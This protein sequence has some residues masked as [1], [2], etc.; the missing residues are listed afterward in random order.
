VEVER[1]RTTNRPK[2]T[3]GLSAPPKRPANFKDTT[4][5]KK[6][7]GTGL[8]APAKR[9][10][11]SSKAAKY[12]GLSAP[13]KRPADTGLDESIRK[14]QEKILSSIV[15]FYPKIKY[16][17]FLPVK[18]VVGFSHFSP[19]LINSTK[20]AVSTAKN[21]ELLDKWV[22]S[23]DNILAWVDDGEQEEIFVPD[24]FSLE[25]LLLQRGQPIDNIRETI[26]TKIKHREDII[27]I[28]DV[29]KYAVNRVYQSTYSREEVSLTFCL[30][31]AMFNV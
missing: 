30:K 31:G 13:A 4:N 16:L 3:T 10:A 6:A 23:F 26:S 1:A 2:G 28:L 5:S 15:Q 14:L 8:S 29:V 17:G 19:Y 9:P 27:N 11:N 25:S 22:Q 7:K 12:T 18:R 21:K 20:E 24:N